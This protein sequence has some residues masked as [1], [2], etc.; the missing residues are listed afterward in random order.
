[1][2]YSY[3]ID[4]EVPSSYFEKLFDFMFRQYLAPQKQ[5]FSNLSKET[6]QTG[7]T[8]SYRVLDQQGREILKVEV[9]G[10]NE[11]DVTITPLDVEIPS[12]I[13][14]E[15]R[16]DVVI[17]I[18]MF[19]EKARKATWYFAW[20]EGEEIVPERVKMQEKSLNSLFL[21]TQI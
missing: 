16:Q 6:T 18:Q 3:K 1:M 20:R 21:E 5:R 12:E 15:A 4:T 7:A 14:E 19:E 10:T 13:I 11:I 9:A 2:P 8:V 17:A